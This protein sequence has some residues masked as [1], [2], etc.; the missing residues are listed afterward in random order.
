MQETADQLCEE[1]KAGIKAIQSLKEIERIVKDQARFDEIFAK[2]P[3]SL[4][5]ISKLQESLTQQIEQV[6]TV[7][8]KAEWE[9]R[10]TVLTGNI[11]E[12]FSIEQEEILYAL[13]SQEALYEETP[14][15]F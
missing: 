10:V 3:L 9:K 7:Y 5:S 6:K 11:Q 14:S 1:I 4:E 13:M 8:G 15:L 2:N 12:E